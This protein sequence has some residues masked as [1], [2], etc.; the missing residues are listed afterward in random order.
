MQTRL[1]YRGGGETFCSERR[2]LPVHIQN[3]PNTIFL[4]WDTWLGLVH[5]WWLTVYDSAF[6][7]GSVY[8]T[9]LTQQH[10]AAL[11]S[12][13]GGVG[14]DCTVASH[15]T[16]SKVGHNIG[17]GCTR[18]LTLAMSPSIATVSLHYGLYRATYLAL[19][20]QSQIC[21]FAQHPSQVLTWC[22]LHWH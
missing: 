18:L 5:S 19:P 22:S 20:M 14:L 6:H 4:R 1:Q 15:G 9:G 21:G 13:R 8:C 12:C 11:R 7:C 2:G 17:M 10:S 16:W 3:I